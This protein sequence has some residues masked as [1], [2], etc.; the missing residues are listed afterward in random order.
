LRNDALRIKPTLKPTLVRVTSSKL[1]ILLGIP[2]WDVG[3]S[4]PHVLTKLNRDED[5]VD[6]IW[7]S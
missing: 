2:A 4:L 7:A 3:P 1:F 6:L 5:L